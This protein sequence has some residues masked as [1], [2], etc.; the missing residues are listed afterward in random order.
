MPGKRLQIE[1]IV[2]PDRDS[3]DEAISR[4]GGRITLLG[5]WWYMS[6]AEAVHAIE[7]GQAS[8]YVRVDDAEV[9]VRVAVSA[10]GNKYLRTVR[11]GRPTNNLLNLRPCD[12]RSGA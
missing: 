4:I 3:R 12:G 10:A 9:D 1:C 6:L 7:T 8:F 5:G 11:D 2:K